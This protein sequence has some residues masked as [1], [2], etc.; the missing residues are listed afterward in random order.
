MNKTFH[1]FFVSSGCIGLAIATGLL[2]FTFRAAADELLARSN[3]RCRWMSG[4]YE[5][6]EGHCVAKQKRRDRDMIFQIDLDNGESMQFIG[7]N[8]DALQ[9]STHDGIHNAQFR[10]EGENGLF[11]WQEGGQRHSLYVKLDTMHNPYGSYDAPAD[12]AAGTAVGAAVGALIGN[13]LSGGRAPVAST[14]QNNNT[15][16]ASS[17]GMVRARAA[18]ETLL[19]DKNANLVLGLSAGD[20]IFVNCSD[21]TWIEGGKR[22]YAMD[23]AGNQ[24][25]ILVN[26]VDGVACN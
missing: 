19:L 13:L 20:L 24:G 4:S 8:R 3:G 18:Y 25:Y 5:V 6:Y 21:T 14:A 12:Q 1:R 22:I 10:D 7:P 11:S 23:Q 9:V 2:P 17:S 16:T 26:A 15:Q